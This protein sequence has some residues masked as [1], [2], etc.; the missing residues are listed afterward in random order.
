MGDPQIASPLV[1]LARVELARVETGRGDLSAME[2][3]LEEALGI[4]SSRRP[5]HWLTAEAHIL[6][7][8]CRRRQLRSAEAEEQLREGLQILETGAASA[9]LETRKRLVEMAQA[10]LDEIARTAKAPD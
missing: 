5:S 1:Y 3:P 9:I 8:S 10:E 7:G 6:L 2:R 4:L